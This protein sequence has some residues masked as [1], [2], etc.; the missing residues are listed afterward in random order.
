M[1][2]EQR[3]HRAGP[4]GEHRG[5][6]GEQAEAGEPEDRAKM[7]DRVNPSASVT[8]VLATDFRVCMLNCPDAA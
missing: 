2:R 8:L 4:D 6:T 7:K 3:K 5:K 1:Y